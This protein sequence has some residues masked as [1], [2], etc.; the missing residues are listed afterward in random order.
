MKRYLIFAV[1][2]LFMQNICAAQERVDICL[3]PDGA[4]A[5]N[6]DSGDDAILYVYHPEKPN[7]QA[8]IMCPGGSYDHLCMTW[9]GHDLAPWFC[10]RGVTYCLLKYRM[11]QGNCEVPLSDARQAM[12]LVRSH[13]EEWGL[14]TDCIGIMGASAGGHLA[15]TLATRHTEDCRPGF[16]ILLY[17]V[18]TMG[19]YTHED[20]RDNLLGENPSQEL[21][22]YFSNELAVTG[23][24][25]P[26]FVAL[27]ADDDGVS[28][29]NSIEY[30]LALMKNGVPVTMHL[31]PSGRHGWGFKDTFE[32]KGSW[33]S[34]LERWLKSLL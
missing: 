34:E 17:P 15:S 26:A 1:L 9:E 22:N 18:I 5:S 6:G 8:V 31:Y 3:W 11:P 33:T 14:R 2:P 24:T 27:S 10:S 32:Y 30:C 16:Q 25:P 28:P 23:D 20:S 21:I 4:P 7:G 19:E 29:V 13:A 12:R